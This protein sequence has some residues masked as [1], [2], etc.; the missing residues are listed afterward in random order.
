MVSTLYTQISNKI[1]IYRKLCNIVEGFSLFP[2]SND[3]SQ[4]NIQFLSYEIR[5]Q[6]SFQLDEQSYFTRKIE[7][8]RFEDFSILES[9]KFSSIMKSSFVDLEYRLTATIS[10]SRVTK[11]PRGTDR[12]FPREHRLQTLQLYR[13]PSQ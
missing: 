3:S 9:Q 13:E 4:I 2:S 1:A 5:V 10:L 6:L 7:R 12:R 11:H 8:N